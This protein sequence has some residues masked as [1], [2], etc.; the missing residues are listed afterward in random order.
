MKQF[1]SLVSKSLAVVF[2]IIVIITLPFALIVF[3]TGRVVFNPDVVKQIAVDAVTEEKVLPRMVKRVVNSE[4]GEEREGQEEPALETLITRLEPSEWERV[5]GQLLSDEILAE[6][7][8]S[9]IDSVYRWLDSDQA[10]PQIG[11]DLSRL[12]ARMKGPHGEQTAQVLFASLPPCGE[13]QLD[14][15]ASDPGQLTSPAA[16]LELWCKVPGI[17]AREQIGMYEFILDRLASQIPEEM[18]LTEELGG[19]GI[20]D[21]KDLLMVKDGLRLVRQSMRY[22]LLVPGVCLVMIALFGARSI[23]GLGGWWGIPLA[24]GS[25]SSFAASFLVPPRLFTL[26]VE[27]T[28]SRIPAFLQPVVLR[29]SQRVITRIFQPL[30]WQSVMGLIVGWVLIGLMIVFSWWKRERSSSLARG[31]AENVL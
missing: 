14:S 28:T 5:T 12:K 30:R 4:D 6:W 2:S 16:M 19:M 17:S 23:E 31:E 3:D 22:A 11:I 10:V 20:E 9:V 18:N 1:L 27:R 26:L 21:K 25:G 24:L 13:E 8:E 15:L 29:G 7:V